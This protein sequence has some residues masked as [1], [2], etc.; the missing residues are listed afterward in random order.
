MNKNFIDVICESQLNEWTFPD[1]CL[2]TK[3]NDEQ[4]ELYLDTQNKKQIEQNKEI[5]EA[6]LAI[7]ALK[8]ELQ[9][10]KIEY[11][12][13]MNLLND[14]HNQ[15]ENAL[16]ILDNE[17]IDLIQDIIKKSV[18]KIIYKE[19]KSDSKLLLKI[20]SELKSS[21]NAQNGLVNVSVSAVDYERLKDENSNPMMIVS[22]N[23]LLKE[24]DIIIKSNFTE[25]RSIL[26][27]RIDK[28]LGLKNE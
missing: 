15:L 16:S 10:T 26:N 25:I 27:D 24:G 8:N 6:N 7:I 20:I 1:V 11:A 13:K 2:E 9:E 23:S 3:T 28:M 17:L 21:I 19:I 14:I 22:E 4:N 12:K 5:T 18:K